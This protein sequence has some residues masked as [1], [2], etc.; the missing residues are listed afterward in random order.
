MPDWFQKGA[1]SSG[2]PAKREGD[3]VQQAAAKAARKGGDVLE[4]LVEIQAKLVLVNAREVASLCGTKYVTYLLPPDSS[5]AAAGLEANKAY[6]AKVQ[7]LKA[8]K[9][10]DDTVD[11]GSLGPPHLHVW[12]AVV[13]ALAQTE[14]SVE[15]R[16]DYKR[17]WDEV[18]MQLPVL[19]LG[20]HIRYFR[21]RAPKGKEKEAKKKKPMVK[22][23]YAFNV[24]GSPFTNLMPI[25][26]ASVDAPKGD[27]KVGPAPRGSLERDAQRLLIKF[28]KGK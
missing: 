16:T 1:A 5:I 3:V 19:Q 14:Q 9:E 20:E 25:F 26:K 4:E 2:L 11:T 8:D 23:V 10:Q 24:E 17:Y 12:T 7:K 27:R 22:L 15:R 6:D 18:I 28:Q 13:L 21:I